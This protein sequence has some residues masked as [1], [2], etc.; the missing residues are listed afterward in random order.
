MGIE[1]FLIN[2]LSSMSFSFVVVAVSLWLFKTSV[3]EQVKNSIEAQFDEQLEVL[4]ARLN[5]ISKRGL[6]IDRAA[7]DAAKKRI[8]SVQRPTLV[9]S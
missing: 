2:I 9:T 7:R 6:R 3:S 1:A 4:K 8:S 5:W